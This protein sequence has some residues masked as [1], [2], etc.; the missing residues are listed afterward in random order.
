MSLKCKN[1]TC[2]AWYNNKCRILTDTSFNRSCPFYKNRQ[3]LENR[4][5]LERHYRMLSL[6]TTDPFYIKCKMIEFCAKNNPWLNV[7]DALDLIDQIVRY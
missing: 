7:E 6:Y 5:N 3:Q 1:D 2:F 4:A